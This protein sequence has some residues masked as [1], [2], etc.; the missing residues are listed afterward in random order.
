MKKTMK[1]IIISN[2][3]VMSAEG[4]RNNK[5]CKYVFCKT[6]GEVF[7]S[8]VDTG[9]ANGVSEST[10]SLCCTGKQKGTNGKT[11]C[12]VE[13]MPEHYEDI[14]RIIRMMYPDWAAAEAKRQ[15][16]A[17]KEEERKREEARLAKEQKRKAKAEANYAKKLARANKAL[18]ELDKRKA[19]LDAFEIAI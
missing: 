16:E 2:E 14:A 10:I 5:N 1:K 8:A 4:K 13:D 19:E 9:E 7:T 6:T 12:Y 11:F 18:E 15:E 3:S 17:R